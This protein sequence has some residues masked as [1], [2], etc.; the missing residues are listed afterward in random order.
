MTRVAIVSGA[1]PAGDAVGNDIRQMQRVLQGQGHAVEVFTGTWGPD[2]PRSRDGRTVPDYLGDDPGGLAIYH[3]ASGWRPGVDLIRRLRCRRVVRYHNV[4]PAH[5]FA[6]YDRGFA[7]D[8]RRGR[9]QLR[10]LVAARCDLY[11]SASAYNQREFL[12]LGAE[13][14]RCAVMYPFHQVD[15][16]LAAVPDPVVR[17]DLDDGRANL[18]FIGRLVPHKGHRFLLDAFAAYLRHHDPDGRL[19]LVGREEWLLH[20]YRLE[21]EQQARRLGIR[22]QMLF[23]FRASEAE[24]RAYFEEATAL[25]VASEHEGFCV[26]VVEAMALGVPVVAYAAAAVPDTVGDAGLVWPEPDPFLLA[27]SA[28]RLARDGRARAA[29][30][31]RGRRRFRDHFD[32]PH[33]EA[34]FV[35]ALAA[36]DVT[37]TPE[38]NAGTKVA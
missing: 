3:H 18:L 25:V 13:A 27:A 35:R 32:L 33:I 12:E 5:F 26:P 23:V 16:L 8:C 37:S 38:W 34:S 10:E 9:E 4:T 36:L 20:G 2:Q 24:L 21:L 31:D 1:C 6:Q 15:R 14:A 17:E 7:E 30:A 22:S 11:L 28:D 29:L 19:I